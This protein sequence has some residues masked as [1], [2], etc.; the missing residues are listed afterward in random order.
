[1]EYI[2][3]DSTMICQRVS[4]SMTIKVIVFV[5][6]FHFFTVFCVFSLP[7]LS[8]V[9]SFNQI[10]TQ[11][12][13]LRMFFEF[14]CSALPVFLLFPICFFSYIFTLFFAALYNNLCIKTKLNLV[15]LVS[16]ETGDKTKKYSVHCGV[17]LHAQ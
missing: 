6:F 2:F 10:R 9:K 1:M 8:F 12:K 16:Q 13:Q 3:R 4:V 7:F 11:Q 5:V 14:Y 17:I 15:T